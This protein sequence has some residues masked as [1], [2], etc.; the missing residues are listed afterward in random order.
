MGNAD[1]VAYLDHG[2]KGWGR[3]TKRPSLP[4]AFLTTMLYCIFVSV[5]GTNKA[6]GFLSCLHIHMT[7]LLLYCNVFI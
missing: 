4:G 5:A 2:L 6:F 7:C 1:A 3:G